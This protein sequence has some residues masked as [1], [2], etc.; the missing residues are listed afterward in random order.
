MNKKL[1]LLFAALFAVSRLSAQ[2]SVEQWGC[3]E[4]SFTAQCD[5]NPFDVRLEATF[6]QGDQSLTV[7]G[8]YDGENTYRIRFMPPT[9]GEWHY[10]TR[11][12]LRALNR[13]QGTITATTPSATNHGPVR[14]DGEH[15]FRYADSKRYH[16]FG[17]TN[18]ALALFRRSTQEATLKSLAQTGFNKTRMCILPKDYPTPH[19]APTLFPYLLKSQQTDAEGKITYEWDFE[20]FNP[21]YFQ[22]IEARISDLLAMGIEADLILFHPYDR[23]MWGFDRMTNDESIRYLR[24]LIARVA[25]YRNVWWSM[26]NEWDLVKYKSRE[27][28]MVLT[29]AVVAA[30]PYRHLC[31]IHGGTAVYYDYHHPEFTHVSFQDEGP[32]FSST[33][34][35]T[36]RQIFRK[37]VICDEFGYE[38]NT[39][40]RWAR[41]SPQQMLHYATNGVMGGIYVTHGECYRDPQA[42]DWVY[43]SD[44]GVLQGESWRRLAFLRSVIEAAPHPVRMADLS[45]D[46]QTSIAGDG[47]WFVYLGQEIHRSWPFNLPASAEQFRRIKAGERFKVEIINLWEMTITECPIRF[48]ATERLNYRHY[49]RLHREVQ[50][51]ETPYL[52]LRITSEEL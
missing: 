24:Y 10:N 11:S 15:S 48:E 42:E 19:E 31:S 25:A 29:R 6:T 17:T 9:V 26:A 46:E 1:L 2:L 49:D 50:L 44:G 7:S 51:P 12:T 4:L 30:D 5:T 38:G 35:A 40:L 37:P 39:S 32:L 45:R 22:Q 33:A 14:V 8:F 23:G 27:D 18:Y 20:R 52:L 21:A 36:L 43:W 47:Y 13:R 3:A 16:P 28:W 41:L 34:S